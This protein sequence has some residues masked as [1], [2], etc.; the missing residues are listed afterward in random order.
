MGARRFEGLA[1]ELLFSA[2]YNTANTTKILTQKTEYKHKTC[3]AGKF[4]GEKLWR[5]NRLSHMVIIIT[6]IVWMV[7]VWRIDDDSPNSPNFPAIR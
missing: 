5:M 4:G 6:T 1:T 7:L 3:N 2:K